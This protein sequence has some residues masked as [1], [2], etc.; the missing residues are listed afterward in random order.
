[1]EDVGRTHLLLPETCAK[2]VSKVMMQK[3][4]KENIILICKMK[5]VFHPD[6]SM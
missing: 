3:L 5:K 2:Q 6:G 4:E 1:V